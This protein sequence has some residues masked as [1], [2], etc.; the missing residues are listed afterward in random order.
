MRKHLSERALRLC[1]A[2]G[3]ILAGSTGCSDNEEIPE[4]QPLPVEFKLDSKTVFVSCDGDE[5]SVNYTVENGLKDATIQATAD[6][7][8]ITDL[9]AADGQISFTVKPS[10]EEEARQATVTA[11]YEA[12]GIEPIEKTFEV[13]Q[14]GYDAPFKITISEITPIS[15]S[16]SM[17]ASAPE[18]TYM[19][20]YSSKEYA[21][22]LTPDEIIVKQLEYYEAIAPATGQTFREVLQQILKAGSFSGMQIKGLLPA[23]ENIVVIAGVDLDGKVTTR[24]CIAEFTTEAVETTDMTFDFRPQI[25]GTSVVIDVIPGDQDQYYFCNYIEKSRVTEEGVIPAALLQSTLTEAVELY[26]TYGYPAEMAVAQICYK[27]AHQLT[28]SDLEADTEYLA[29]AIAVSNEGYVMSETA[30]KEFTTGAPEPVDPSDN[31]LTMQVST[32]TP[33]TVEI[34]ITATNQDP[35]IVYPYLQ[36]ELEGLS[37]QEII[38]KTVKNKKYA[39]YREGSS[40]VNYY[41]QTPGTAYTCVAFGF[42]SQQ[43]TTGLFRCDYTTPASKSHAAA[44]AARPGPGAHEIA[45]LLQKL[46]GR[47][48]EGIIPRAAF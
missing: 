9:Q 31:Q 38:E 6:K 39:D 36:S 2:L 16:V 13:R 45:P 43:V 10:S 21:G 44:G 26:Y 7:E 14:D 24:A 11:V 22:D 37:E 28:G 8:W 19:I 29:Y 27:G 12:A 34:R 41:N 32:L 47:Q 18:Q 1:M 46:P 3:L 48:P 4:P 5:Q 40:T 15:A 23:S 35:Y 20:L 33:N 25:D 30:Q 42:Q 17:T